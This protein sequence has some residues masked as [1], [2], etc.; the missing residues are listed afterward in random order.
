MIQEISRQF[1]KER[2]YASLLEGIQSGHT[3]CIVSGMCDSSRPFFASS[4]LKTLGKKGLLVVPEEKDAYALQRLLSAFFERVLVYP[5]RDFVFETVAAHSREWEHERLNVLKSVCDGKYDVVITVPDALM[6]YTVPSTVLEQQTVRLKL[7]D[8]YPVGKLCRKLEQM[9]YTSA[10]VV[11]GVGQFSHRGGIVDVFSPQ[12][13]EPLRIDFFGDEVDL[14]GFFDTVA[15]RTI[16]NAI[17]AEILP[18]E[19]LLPDEGS[20]LRLEA[21][22]QALLKGFRG[23]EKYRDQL[24][25]TLE[26]V[27]RREKLRYADR[28]YPLLYGKAFSLAD[29][30]CKDEDVLTL[31]FDSQRV[32]ERAK[33]FYAETV[34]VLTSLAEN[35]LVRLKNGLPLM[36]QEQ[37]ASA[38]S[39]RTVLADLF[40]HSGVAFGAKASYTLPTQTAAN[41]GGNPEILAEELESL[42]V[43]KT[44][45]LFVTAGERAAANLL[46]VLEQKGIRALPYNGKLHPG[47]VSVC[48]GEWE[49]LPRGFSLPSA[50]FVLFTDASAGTDLLPRKKRRAVSRKA[51]RIASYADLSVGDLVVHVNHGIGRYM[52]IQNLTA[53]GVSRDFIKIVYAD[54][55]ILYV[56]CNQLDLVSKYVG[57]D[58]HTKLSKMGGAEWKRAKLRAKAAASNIAKD[59]IRLYAERRA[60]AGY[61]FP[62]DDD[63]QE[64]FEGS[65]EYEDT[66]GQTIASREIKEDMQRTYPMDRL[67]CGDVGFGKTEVALRAVF[68]CVFAGKQAAILVPTTILSAQ[69]YQT[70]LARFRGYPIEVG[71]VSRFVPK[72]TQAETLERLKSGRLNVIVGTHRLLQKDVEFKDLGLLIVDEEQRFGV[73]H[74]EKL[75]QLAKDVDVLTLTATPIPRTLN[76]ALSG[77]RDM[78]VLEEAPVDR[79]P[80]QTFVL[81]HEEDV[82]YEAIRRELRRGGQVFYLHNFIDSIH[83]KA[84]ELTKQFPEASIAIAHGRMEREDLSEV[85]R[86]M[87]EGRIDILVC[88]TIIETGVNLP[89]ANT[90]IIE[91]ANRMGLA[92][93]HQIRGRVGRSSRKAYAYLTYRKG[94]ELTEIAEK[95]LEAIREYTEFGS[96]FKIAMRD[97]EL[98]G[99]G[100][101]LGAE[102]SGHMEAIGYDLYVKILEDAVNAEKGIEPKAERNCI[103]DLRTDAFIPESY[104]ASSRLRMDVYRKIVTVASEE[105]RQDLEDELTDR[106]GDLPKAV[107]NLVDVSLIRHAA[108]DAGFSSIEQREGLVCFYHPMLFGP[109]AMRLPHAEGFRGRVMLTLSGRMHIAVRMPQEADLLGDIRKLLQLYAQFSC[110]DEE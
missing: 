102:Q 88:T 67:L 45:V 103:V 94:G 52:G 58:E 108:M 22:L 31:V 5:A 73:T 17:S 39:G 15:Q 57:G 29:L 37:F 74:K 7:G 20:Y 77:I 90:L 104:I 26:A 55:G 25:Q 101:I 6:Q 95:R 9:G 11:E 21:E 30:L 38:L 86:D 47:V 99:A 106:F 46:S 8:E 96:G 85:W 14:I 76:M 60:R 79:V 109:A 23:E 3:P 84:A 69:H 42:L 83:S 12:Y 28:Y 16:D 27:S 61:A 66:E 33:G 92:Q 2:E 43:G 91:E 68:K 110:R 34:G 54:G 53:D 1:A 70:L 87:V 100:N 41:Y 72:K 98:R 107:R 49:T 32:L 56:P 51:E 80:V 4:V 50:G 75:K 48:A 93:L 82:L 81:E 35:R 78:S 71:E 40:S 65:F 13:R 44:Q 59:L 36:D 18:C 105:E 62:P 10:E 24:K 89:N 97:L 63:L 19:E 64:E